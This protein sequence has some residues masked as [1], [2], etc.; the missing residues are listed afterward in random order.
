M[1]A[2][3]DI[4]TLYGPEY[5]RLYGNS[6]PQN[7]R[8]AISAIRQCRRGPFGLNVFHC[9]SCG[10]VHITKCSCG[11][12]HC[13]T[14]QNDKAEQWLINQSRNLLP[15]SYFLITFTVPKDLRP[16]CRSNQQAAY[17]AMFSAASDALRT[18]AK[19][20]RFCGAEKTAILGV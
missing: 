16:F 17:S 1:S 11:N 14:C 13:P 5:L 8:R 2:I 15:C 12:R 20:K 3:Q 9:D 18:L 10:S 19:D 6:M 4:F 7:H